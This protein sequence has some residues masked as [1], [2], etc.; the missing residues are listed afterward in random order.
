MLR[1]LDPF[2]KQNHNLTEVMFD[3]CTLDA[4]G[5]QLMA[6]AIGGCSGSLTKFSIEN[7]EYFERVHHSNLYD[8]VCIP[9]ALS[10]HPEIKEIDLSGIDI[11]R[12]TCVALATLIKN[13]TTEL[14]DLRIDGDGVDDAGVIALVGGLHHSKKLS[15]LTLGGGQHGTLSNAGWQSI[16]SLLESPSSNLE[17]LRLFFSGIGTD[18]ALMLANSLGCNH[19]LKSLSLYVDITTEVWPIFAKLVCD[20]TSINR[21]FQSNHTLTAIYLNDAIPYGLRSLLCLNDEADKK[22]VAMTK[23]LKHHPHFNMEPFFE[24]DLKVLPL[25]ISWFERAALISIDFEAHINERKFS[26]FY[27]FVRGMPM[28]AIE[29]WL[30]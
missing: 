7:D 25:M 10:M 24:W 17:V 1:M 4:E 19:K 16:S 6:M 18:G 30:G 5:Y 3:R 21:T 11:G 2:F 27:Q 28:M 29:S 26:S 13:T 23:I 8:P 22:K 14:E 9:L 12:N 20:T 15:T